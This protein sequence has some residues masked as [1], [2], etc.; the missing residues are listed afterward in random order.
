[1]MVARMPGGFT[2]SEKGNDRY[3]VDKGR[4]GLHPVP[5]LATSGRLSRV[6]SAREATISAAFSG[7][8]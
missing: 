8:S 6:G 7:R 2:G 3:E 4:Q 5:S 1:M